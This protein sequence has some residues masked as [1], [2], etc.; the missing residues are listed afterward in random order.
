[1]L[2]FWKLSLLGGG[3]NF[4]GFTNNTISVETVQFGYYDYSN[5]SSIT[6]NIT[7]LVMGASFLSWHERVVQPTTQPSKVIYKWL[8]L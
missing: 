2:L 4:N 1:M 7:D 3:A 6:A 8:L 5:K